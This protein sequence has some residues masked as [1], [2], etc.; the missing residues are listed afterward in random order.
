M[1]I[2]KQKNGQVS[3][4]THKKQGSFSKRTEQE[5]NNKVKITEER[6]LQQSVDPLDQKP[7]A[8]A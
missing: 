1:P 8:S 4:D 5:S 7:T 3:R 2:E 6:P